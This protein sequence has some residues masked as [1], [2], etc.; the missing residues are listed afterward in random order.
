MLNPEIVVSL[1]R[2]RSRR[3]EKADEQRYCVGRVLYHVQATP[4]D[5]YAVNILQS[6]GLQT[7]PQ[8]FSIVEAYT[9][10]GIQAAL[11]LVQEDHSWLDP[12]IEAATLAKEIAGIEDFK[13]VLDVV[14]EHSQVY[15]V[16]KAGGRLLPRINKGLPLTTL[17]IPISSNSGKWYDPQQGPVK[18]YPAT[19][20]D[21]R[22]QRL[23]VDSDTGVKVALNKANDLLM[24]F[25]DAY[26][27]SGSGYYS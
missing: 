25:G 4:I 3:T 2:N 12:V 20:F 16:P 1:C 9:L 14:K 22:R 6:L 13:Y 7:R 17:A 21:P 11:D 24:C 19:R 27:K 10:E 8:L 15:S 18:V 5:G 23:T 26:S